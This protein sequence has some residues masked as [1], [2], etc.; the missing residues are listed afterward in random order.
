MNWLLVV[1]LGLF[2]VVEVAGILEFVEVVVVGV[3]GV[4]EVVG[5]SLLLFGLRCC[6]PGA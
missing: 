6:E 3:F 1:I 5:G 2:G 4:F